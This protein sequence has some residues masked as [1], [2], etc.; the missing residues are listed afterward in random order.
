VPSRPVLFEL[1]M[2]EAAFFHMILCN[3]AL[4][5]DV[6][7]G[8]P[9]S[10]EAEFHKMAAISSVNAALQENP[11]VSDAIIGAVSYLAKVEVRQRRHF[12]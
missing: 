2:T 12:V 8:R 9:E 1:A 6:L 3:S 7:S 10:R 5:V 4:Y 11:N